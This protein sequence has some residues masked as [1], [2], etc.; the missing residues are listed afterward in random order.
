MVP[1]MDEIKNYEDL[2]RG[3]KILFIMPTLSTG[4]AERVMVTVIKYINRDKYEPTLL[5]LNQGNN[6]LDLEDIDCNVELINLKVNRL[7]NAPLK[8]LSAIKK[9]NPDTV[10][11]T[12]GYLNELLSVLIPFL[13]KKVKYI[14]R[15]S[16]IP[17]LRNEADSNRRLHNLIYNRYM[18]RFDTIICQSNDMLKDLHDN[19]KVPTEQMVVIDNPVDREYIFRK[20][21]EE[22]TELK[23]EDRNILAVG[24]LKKVKNYKLLIEEAALSDTNTKYWILGEGEERNNLEKLISTKQLEDKVV[25]LGHQK[26]PWKYMSKAEEFWQKSYWEGNSNAL[27]EWRLI[28]GFE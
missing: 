3:R 10:I 17:S 19:F 18:H 6:A 20:S 22:C 13:P 8:L 4:G 23:N 15:E 12:L 24:S 28:R 9:Y 11:S 5:V 27:K 25:L 21:L 2:F 1:S 26:N 14:A 16:S 7:R